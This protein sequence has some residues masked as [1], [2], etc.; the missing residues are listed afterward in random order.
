MDFEISAGRRY[1]FRVYRSFEVGLGDVQLVVTDRKR[2]DGSL[3][4]EQI[5]Y[6]NTTAPTQVLNFRC[7]LYIP[8]RRRQTRYVTKLG[9]GKDRKIYVIP[10]AEA[11]RGKPLRLQAEEIDGLRVLN[12]EWV[13]GK[14]WGEK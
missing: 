13:V 10:N 6:N 8:G 1:K 3:E 12:Y 14:H 9:R 2:K 4:I 7:R 5:I 11:L